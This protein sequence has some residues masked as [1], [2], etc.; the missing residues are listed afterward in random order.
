MLAE[1]GAPSN[2]PVPQPVLFPPAPALVA[3]SWFIPAADVHFG[4]PIFLG[5]RPGLFRALHW[6]S[7]LNACVSVLASLLVLAHC[8][9]FFEYPRPRPSSTA[10]A[11]AVSSPPC[12]DPPLSPLSPRQTRAASKDITAAVFE[13]RAMHPSVSSTTGGGVAPAP[14]SVDTLSPSPR[15]RA[16]RDMTWRELIMTLMKSDFSARFPIY[17]AVVELVFAAVHAFDHVVLLATGRFPGAPQCVAISTIVSI[18]FGF[19]QYY[20]GFLSFFTY[21]KVVRGVHL[22]LGPMDCYLHIP[23]AFAFAVLGV[24]LHLTD[25]LGPSGFTCTF[26]IHV[27]SGILLAYIGALSATF[28]AVSGY[29]SYTKIADE[30]RG[31]MVQLQSV[32]RSPMRSPV[33]PHDTPSTTSESASTS[34]NAAISPLP[35]LYRRRRSRRPRLTEHQLI[36]RS[37]SYLLYS[38]IACSTPLALG[39]WLSAIFATLGVVEPISGLV[40]VLAPGASGWCNMWAYFATARIKSAAARARIRA[41]SSA[42][43]PA[44]IAAG[45]GMHG[46]GSLS[47]AGQAAAALAAAQGS[48]AKPAPSASVVGPGRPPPSPADLQIMATNEL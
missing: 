3:T 32:M 43:L 30:V 4:G 20:A 23:I 7:M 12:S 17:I 21:L 34:S 44:I 26:N 40:Y 35:G 42:E 18:A 8:V 27:P 38:S 41:S 16:R 22:P 14:S 33:H 48:L 19:Q 31:T 11:S 37:L 10:P 24:V 1:H 13:M 45:P 46:S 5:T 15:A 28:N 2:A 9:G 36:L 29:Y 39:A 6:I 47:A 25:G